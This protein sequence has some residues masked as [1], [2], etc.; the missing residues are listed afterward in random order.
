MTII[1]SHSITAT[2]MVITRYAPGVNCNVAN[3]VTFNARYI[4][5]I[6]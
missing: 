1:I 5:C 3:V 2:I 6:K 4:N